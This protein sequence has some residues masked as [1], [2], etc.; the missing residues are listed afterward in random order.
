MNSPFEVL[1]MT[2]QKYYLV[3]EVFEKIKTHSS[4][5]RLYTS[6]FGKLLFLWE[7]SWDDDAQAKHKYVQVK[8]S[9]LIYPVLW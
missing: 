9:F 6:I 1:A 7:Y 5:E 4:I 8:H 3:F 2:Y